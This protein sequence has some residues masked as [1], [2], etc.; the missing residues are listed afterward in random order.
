MQK[1]TLVNI[2]VFLTLVLWASGVCASS[3]HQ[4][5]EMSS[6]QSNISPFHKHAK[7][8]PSLKSERDHLV[9]MLKH[10]QKELPC[11]HSKNHKKHKAFVIESDCSG[12]PAGSIPT[13]V[14]FS[15]NLFFAF[16]VTSLTLDN[17]PSKFFPLSSGY[18]FHLPLQIDHPPKFL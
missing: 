18:R 7:M 4:H 15:K 3:L 1:V 5:A 11:P 9:C 16:K 12:K 17:N 6:T 14:D 2:C 13:S 8:G 10:H